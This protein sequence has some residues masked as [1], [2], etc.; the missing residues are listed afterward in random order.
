MC[1]FND[2]HTTYLLEQIPVVRLGHID[3]G[4][5]DRFHVEQEISLSLKLWRTLPG[6]KPTSYS[7]STLCCTINER[8]IFSKSQTGSDVGVQ[9]PS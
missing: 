8:W 3:R 2:L 7:V 9:L 6:K 1:V 5:W 4:I